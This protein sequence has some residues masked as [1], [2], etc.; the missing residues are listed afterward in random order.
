MPLPLP[1]QPDPL[2]EG[3]EELCRSLRLRR[4]SR[5]PLLCRVRHRLHLVALP[6]DEP[7]P[8]TA[9]WYGYVPSPGRTWP[10]Q[11]NRT[12]SVIWTRAF[13]PGSP[14][15][16]PPAPPRSRGV[17][18]P[19]PGVPGSPRHWTA[20]QLGDGG[21]PLD[22]DVNDT[23]HHLVAEL[24]ANTVA[25]GRSL[26]RDFELRLP[27]LTDHTPR[28]EVSDERGDRQSRFEGSPDRGSGPGLV[29]VMLLACT[30]GVLRRK[31]G[32]TVCVEV[33]CGPVT[34]KS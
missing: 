5:P 20:R 11:D 18:A 23:V 8:D 28:I 26:A 16:T 27:L 3:N 21:F 17:S 6:A 31:P 29:L 10:V 2:A 22:S 13:T 19:R 4:S 32:K 24:A 12:R 1:E 9:Q 30:R 25:Q 14:P 7:T 33:S 15:R 34:S